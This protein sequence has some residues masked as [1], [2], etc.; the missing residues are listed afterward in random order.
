MRRPKFQ[1]PI[2]SMVTDAV[3][4]KIGRAMEG[5]R[6]PLTRKIIIFNLVT[7]SLLVSGILFLSQSRTSLTDLRKQ[8]LLADASV[9][10]TS[11]EFQMEFSD[12]SDLYEPTLYTT[13]ETLAEPINARAQLFSPEGYLI[14]DI[15]ARPEVYHRDENPVTEPQTE[16]VGDILNDAWTRLAAVFVTRPAPADESYL[17]AFRSAIAVRSMI[18][19][20]STLATTMNEI[21]QLIVTVAVPVSHD[22]DMVGAVVL[23]TRG[24]EIDG[25]IW[26]ERQQI[27]EIFI[28]AA[29]TSVFLSILLANTI[30]RPLRQL[31]M[32][33]QK[34]SVQNTGRI[35]P[36][37]IDIPDLTSR[38]DE[39]G[40]LSRQLRNMTTALYDRI[41]ANEAFAA[42]VAH[43]LKNPL[44]SLGSAVETM[45][46]VKNDE[47]RERLMD[48]IR[49]DV[50]RMDR[51]VT[52]I[53]N[54]SRLD[55]E[56]ATDEM[57]TIDVVKMLRDLVDYQSELATAD[58][59]SI[60][61]NFDE[62]TPNIIG[63]KSRLAQVFV[64]LISNAVSFVPKGGSVTVSVF[65][66]E[67]G[68]VAIVIEDT[69]CGIPD[70]NLEDV[71][72]RFYSS[73]PKQ[74]FGNNSGLG[75]SISQ[76]I[77]EAHGGEIWAENIYGDDPD[78]PSG[79]RFTVLLPV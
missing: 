79:A 74:E 69:G 33:A 16:S 11:L 41:E 34:G 14:T 22:G 25:Y 46:L 56:L 68:E 64:N 75:L 76:Q 49:D 78:T 71:F 60:I 29:V 72:K 63:L 18:A 51:L 27:L 61:S 52:D 30:G 24:G 7:L 44:T 55:A 6:S 23:S 54:A 35:S 21:K 28:L 65:Q 37:R 32:A 38:P 57:V 66:H 1:R 5:S 2:P 43:E 53:S 45:R 59:V 4:D 9:L 73:R 77:V 40:D 50:N 70:D 19:D 62:T 42:D 47:A 67:R 39:I 10:A 31:A 3:P 13:L 58:G 17:M 48:V 8:T 15:G 20:D 26:N 36:G 12:I